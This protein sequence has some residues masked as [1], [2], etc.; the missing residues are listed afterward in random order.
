MRVSFFLLFLPWN[1]FFICS[2]S[3]ISAIPALLAVPVMVIPSYY[4]NLRSY[5]SIM[6]YWWSGNR[7]SNPPPDESR[8]VRRISDNSLNP[9]EDDPLPPSDPN[10]P[11]D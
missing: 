9:I 11:F 4:L 5:F 10:R 1:I 6:R 7:F 2:I 8:P 3:V